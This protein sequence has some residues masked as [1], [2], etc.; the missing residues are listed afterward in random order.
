MKN[1]WHNKR[2]GEV[3]DVVNGGTP[4][5]AF[6][7]YWNGEHLWITPAE[8]GKRKSPYVDNT[9]RKLTDAGLR[10]SSARMLPPYS[11]I[12]SSRAPIG[13]LVINIKPMSTNQGCKGLIPSDQLDYKFLYYYLRSIVDLLE[14]LGSGATFKELS[15]SKL[16]DVYIPVPPLSEQQRIVGVLDEAFA[17]LATVQANVEKNLYNSSAL[18]ESYI[19]SVFTHHRTGWVEKPLE[20]VSSILN[21]FA[22][23][24]TDFSS[25]VG[26]KCVKITNVGI[27]TFVAESDVYLP[28]HF[29]KDYAAVSLKAGC[30]V[31]ALTRTIIA[32]G[33][34]VAIVPLEYEGALLNQRVAAIQTNDRVLGSKF[35]FAYLSTQRVSQYVTEHV[36][37]LMQPNLSI[38]D[39]R[40]MPIPIPP[41]TEQL[42]I[43]AQLDS[44]AAETQ[45][46][47]RM[48][49]QKLAALAALKK[50]LLHQAF[51]GEL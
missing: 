11:V 40:A 2:I 22:F 3:C 31:I 5:T 30:I 12:L 35:L 38:V 41:V 50:S 43:T 37:T 9:E 39:L 15:G 46:L 24:S 4:K 44:L 18:F 47:R 49:N 23:K 17:G 20:S 28:N 36:N 51:T 10:D 34:K 16:K 13:H 48:Y 26:T 32:A 6:A 33:L 19:Q 29:S 25:Q 21:G 27:R 45:R 1:G 7:E 8:M 14:A 42:R